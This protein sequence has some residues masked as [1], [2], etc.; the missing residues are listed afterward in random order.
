M[1]EFIE[2]L[3]LSQTSFSK[4]WK[5]LLLVCANIHTNESKHLKG[6]FVSVSNFCLTAGVK[7][8]QCHVTAGVKRRRRHYV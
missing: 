7:I 3:D 4:P 2:Y 6:M 8:V 5:Y 1:L